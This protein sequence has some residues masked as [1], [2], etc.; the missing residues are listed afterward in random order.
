MPYLG[1]GGP[2]LP[3]YTEYAKQQPVYPMPP[4]ASNAPY[5]MPP[6]ASNAPLPY[7]PPDPS[8]NGYYP[9]P[10]QYLPPNQI[11]YGQQPGYGPPQAMYGPPQPIITQP[12]ATGNDRNFAKC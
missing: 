2:V 10:N 12:G 9:P 5:P 1:D 6:N 4:N 11:P 3:P 8:F 7:G